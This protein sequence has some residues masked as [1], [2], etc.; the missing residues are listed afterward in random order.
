M[1]VI[2]V[3]DFKAHVGLTDPVNDDTAQEILDAA[4]SA[5]AA[6]VG[7]LSP[8]TKTYASPATCSRLALPVLPVVSVETPSGVT[9]VDGPAGIVTGSFTAD[10]A[11]TYTAGYADLPADL[12]LAVLELAR[13]L[14]QSSQRGGRPA[15][16]ATPVV[17]A[18]M[19]G[20]LL[21]NAVAALLEPYTMPGFA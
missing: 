15:G 2:A 20:Y 14:W 10:G 16:P 6:L 7:P 9:V 17:G 12:R 5:V 21:P 1:S 3:E 8:T 13:H 11:V 4:E 19:G 18:P